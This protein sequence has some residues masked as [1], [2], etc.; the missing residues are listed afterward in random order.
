MQSAIMKE[1]FITICLGLVI[2][3]LTAGFLEALHVLAVQQESLNT[4]KWPLHVFFLPAVLVFLYLLK[5][6]TLYFPTNVSELL[7]WKSDSSLH[8]SAW[9]TPFNLIGTL[10]S[11]VVGASVGRESVVVVMAAGLVRVFRLEWK[12]WGPIAMGCGFASVL[13]N[14]WIGVVFVVELLTTNFKQKFFVFVS[15]YF[16]YLLM[17][18]MQVPHLIPG[19]EI[20]QDLGFFKT[21]FFVVTLAILVGF[22]MRIYKWVFLKVSLFFRKS[23]IWV[24][25]V[26]AL[27]LM[28]LLL[29]PELRSYQSLG[30]LQLEKLDRLQLGFQIPLLKLF[31]TLFSVTLGFWGG[32]FIPLVYAG[33]H[34]G[35]SLSHSLGYP[36]LVG[37]YLCSYLFFACATRLKW[38]G[39]FLAISLMGFSWALWIFVL[40]NLAVGFS[41]EKSLYQSHD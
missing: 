31:L 33:L 40:V 22:L 29:T 24:R 10:F 9:M 11:H 14:P 32:E 36:Q 30:I 20:Q 2:G 25:L 15:S 19:I 16:A 28:A 38:T 27:I 37:T 1:L 5:K 26:F 12:F 41:G 18:T 8:W 17:Q 34:F 6:R 4:D 39:A 7:G 13:G 35:A 23:S 3:V 21:L